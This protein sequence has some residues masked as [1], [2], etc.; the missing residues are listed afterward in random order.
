MGTDFLQLSAALIDDLFACLIFLQAKI[1]DDRDW[2]E[3][4]QVF[5]TFEVVGQLPWPGVLIH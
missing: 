4:D 1:V 5:N 2:D 3:I